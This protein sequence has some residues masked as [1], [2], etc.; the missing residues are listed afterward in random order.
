MQN[1]QPIIP[2]LGNSNISNSSGAAPIQSS[3]SSLLPTMP[4][5]ASSSAAIAA[6]SSSSG[7]SNSNTNT[8]S[9]SAFKIAQLNPGLSTFMKQNVTVITFIVLEQY[10][11]AKTKD[12]TIEQYLVA[13]ETAAVVL[14]MW[15]YDSSIKLL[16]GDICRVSG[17]FVFHI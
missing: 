8:N 16:P 6:S 2:G 14:R 3:N 1:K 12:H 4:G 10:A 11:A 9:S 13:D 7:N 17:G 15:D 5:A